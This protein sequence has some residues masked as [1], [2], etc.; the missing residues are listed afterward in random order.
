MK[1][2]LC[3]DLYQKILTELMNE[4]QLEQIKWINEKELE[5]LD[6][7]MP[8]IEVFIGQPYFAVPKVL[9]CFPNLKWVQITSAG[10][11]AVD[12]DY[13]R[14]KKIY[15]TN[16]RGVMSASIAEDVILKMLFFSRNVRLFEASRQKHQWENYGW[17][18]Y[19]NQMHR[20]L[21]GKTIGILGDG[22]ISEEIAKRVAAFEM[23]VLVYGRHDKGNVVP[24]SSFFSGRDGLYELAEKSD[25]VVC[26]LPGTPDTKHLLDKEFFS[27]MKKSGYF[28]NIARGMIV[29]EE[30]LITVLDKKLIAG[31]ALDVAEQE[32]LPADSA[33]WEYENVF[34]TFHKAGT[35]DSWVSKL[36]H[37]VKKNI[38]S[39]LSGDCQFD[40]EIKVR[41]EG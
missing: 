16:T 18:Q 31:A 23:D 35:G 11:D 24:C 29:K 37:L 3:I 8:G 39:F 4:S 13:L 26:A 20:D 6:R 14:E 36:G 30:D 34:L 12:L 25:Y 10:Y 38:E 9:Q 28:V 15:L 1:N 2:I 5:I 22:S 21:L 7:K 33:L 40:N 27:H 19:M 17:N 41:E 32:P